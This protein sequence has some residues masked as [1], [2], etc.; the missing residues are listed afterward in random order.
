MY[1]RFGN[2]HITTKQKLTNEVM[3]H[4]ISQYEW[5]NASKSE[6]MGSSLFLFVFEKNIDW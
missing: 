4:F 1:D 5:K 2:F 6:F 3:Q